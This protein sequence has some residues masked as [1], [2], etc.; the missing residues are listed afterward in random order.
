MGV[1]KS[2]LLQIF[3]S[4]RSVTQGGIGMGVKT[5]M[6]KGLTQPEVKQ[7]SNM[8]VVTMSPPRAFFI[9]A[10]PACRTSRWSGMPVAHCDGRQA[11]RLWF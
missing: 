4:I 1:W 11:I 9:P 8:I 7:G 3:S 6:E 5:P 10:S 2:L